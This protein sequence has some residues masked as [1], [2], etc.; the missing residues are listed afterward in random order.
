M[1]ADFREV[2]VI[3]RAPNGVERAWMAEVDVTSPI[4][5]LL[6]ADLVQALQIEGEADDYELLSEGGVGAHSRSGS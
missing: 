6:L 4:G 2:K 5:A 3:L 1:V